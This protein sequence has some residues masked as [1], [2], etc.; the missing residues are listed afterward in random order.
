MTESEMDC[1]ISVLLTGRFPWFVTVEEGMLRCALGKLKLEK[2]I[3]TDES[4]YPSII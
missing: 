3:T 2:Y 4:T 1:L